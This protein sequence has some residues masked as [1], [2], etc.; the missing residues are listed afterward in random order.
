MQFKLPQ[1]TF[2]KKKSENKNS[3]VSVN[4]ELLLLMV[5]SASRIG[6]F[7]KI[8]RCAYLTLCE[9]NQSS[10]GNPFSYNFHRADYGPY[11]PQIPKDLDYLIQAELLSLDQDLDGK[12][13]A[14]TSL[15]KNYLE[16]FISKYKISTLECISRWATECKQM[17][18]DEFNK[19]VYTL[20]QI[21]HYELGDKMPFI[22]LNK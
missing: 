18:S 15:G 7:G 22:V 11:D 1:I 5:A 10:G 17:S 6:G 2:F 4:Q 20:A 12:V 13:V 21:F 8:S 9:L 14:L 3:Q 19:K 16:K